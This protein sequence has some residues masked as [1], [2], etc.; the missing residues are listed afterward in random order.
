MKIWA[1]IHL[2]EATVVSQPSAQP[3]LQPHLLAL[4][5]SGNQLPAGALVA[6]PT[7]SVAQTSPVRDAMP[8]SPPPTP[9]APVAQQEPVGLQ[10]FPA[11][12]EG[13]LR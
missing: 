5:H 6:V 2:C 7:L 12:P 11:Q 1:Q 13:L 8:S 3:A 4:C 10:L 9:Q